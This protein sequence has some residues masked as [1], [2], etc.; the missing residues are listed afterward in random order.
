MINIAIDG[1]AGAG[2]S[3]IAKSLAHSLGYIYVDTGA[4]YRAVGLNALRFGYD[5]KDEKLVTS[6]LSKIKVELKF[7]NGVQKIYLNNE[8]VSEDIRT[9]QA[10]MAASNVSAI[11]SVREYLFDLQQN[12][13]DKNNCIMDGRDIGTVVLPNAQVK[14]FLTASVEER[15]NRRYKELMEKNIEIDYNSVLEEMEQRDF[16]DS[17]REIAPLKPAD[18]A[19]IVDTTNKSLPQ[20][21]NDIKNIVEERV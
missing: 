1:P 15:A 18:D 9:P 4:L 16:Q 2:K 14:I 12:I 6:T 3:T 20:V 10:S 21:I 5:T 13:A 19:I 17:N 8:D 7:I 11:A